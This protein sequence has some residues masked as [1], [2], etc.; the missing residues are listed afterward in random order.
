MSV[1]D[2]RAR[3]QLYLALESHLGTSE[4]DT[5]MNMLPPVG[6]ADVA[7]K[8]DFT[9]L[10]PKFEAIDHRFEA[11]NRRFDVIDRRFE[12]MNTRFEMV[13]RRFDEVDRRFDDVDRRFDEVVTKAEFH[14]ELSTMMRTMIVATSGITGAYAALIVTV[15]LAL[16]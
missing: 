10:D 13:D 8:H 14:N 11:V 2:E 9:M 16:R 12:V 1:L 5:M 6:W 7:T 15:M 4:A 3:H